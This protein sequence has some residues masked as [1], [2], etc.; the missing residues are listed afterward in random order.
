MS[1]DKA[2]TGT[3]STALRAGSGRGDKVMDPIDPMGLQDDKL[4]TS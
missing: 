4:I 1:Q 2:D 3:R